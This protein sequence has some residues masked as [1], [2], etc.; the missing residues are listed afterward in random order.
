MNTPP[1]NVIPITSKPIEIP[2]PGFP[3]LTQ[4]ISHAP[5]PDMPSGICPWVVD[6]PHPLV[7]EMKVVRM[8]VVDGGVHI[9]SAPNAG[10]CTRSFVPMSG[11]KLTEE[12]M[13]FDLF[14]E[15][16]A[17]TVDEP[18]APLIT[19]LVSNSFSRKDE[20]V[21][22]TVGRPNPCSLSGIGLKILRIL[23]EEDV[24]IIYSMANDSSSGTRHHIPVGDVRFTEE[25]MAPDLFVS[26]MEAAEDGN[27]DDDDLEPEPG[28][29]GEPEEPELPA[30][31]PTETPSNGSQT[32]PS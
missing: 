22:W 11:V 6:Q 26:E 2:E 4:M 28:E 25:A 16:L 10:V 17:R 15:E 14:V 32:A 13:P 29:P 12:V 8:F 5:F 31:A 7:P 19:R 18:G 27:D 1:S 23:V 3:M 9:Y 30:V 20:T 21:I 24:A